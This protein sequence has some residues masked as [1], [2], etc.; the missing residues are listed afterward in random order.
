MEIE[1]A[2]YRAL[3]RYEFMKRER[4]FTVMAHPPKGGRLPNG[5]T[6][7]F[8]GNPVEGTCTRTRKRA[9]PPPFMQIAARVEG[10]SG[11]IYD[12]S[13][14]GERRIL[15]WV[16]VPTEGDPVSPTD[17]PAGSEEQ[18]RFIWYA[19]SDGE[20]PTQ[21]DEE[22]TAEF[23]L[24]PYTP[25]QVA[26][27]IAMY[28]SA[29]GG[30][31]P[32]LP[33]NLARLNFRD[34]PEWAHTY[35]LDPLRIRCEDLAVWYDA[36]GV[37]LGWPRPVWLPPQNLFPD[38]TFV[39]DGAPQPDFRDRKANTIREVVRDLEDR[40]E[41]AFLADAIPAIRAGRLAVM[42]RAHRRD[43]RV[44]GALM[45]VS[46]EA[47]EI[48]MQD[49]KG[50]DRKEFVLGLLVTRE[51]LAAWYSPRG[52]A[53]TLDELWPAPSAPTEEASPL[54]AGG[55]KHPAEQ[56]L[57]TQQETEHS[58]PRRGRTKG[59]GRQRADEPYLEEMHRLM[60]EKPSLQP[61]PAAEEVAERAKLRGEDIGSG[62]LKSAAKRLAL[63]Y[64]EKF[65][66]PNRAQ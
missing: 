47:I 54:P 56:L 45:P 44:R 5:D 24:V 41:E 43:P 25:D 46:P 37:A 19:Q 22:E 48:M 39:D 16:V 12:S 27:G 40:R 62:T 58:K 60:L 2:L 59:S 42:T 17:L 29:H 66:A 52:Q 7:S 15:G 34:L 30:D 65:S 6:E 13:I 50:D 18:Q 57:A 49:L 63:R 23:V 61:H 33:A 32:K 8:S 1:T 11:A 20:D 28:A 64:S 21:P 51:A 10:V 9:E 26:S 4:S 36:H 35:Y 31:L 3:M 38:L 55:T 53:P 14:C